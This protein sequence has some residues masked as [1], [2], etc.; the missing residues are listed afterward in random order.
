MATAMS[1]GGGQRSGMNDEMRAALVAVITS[2]GLFK[3]LDWWAQ[4][5]KERSGAKLAH[6]EQVWLRAQAM[7]DRQEKRITE[8]DARLLAQSA[9]IAELRRAL[10]QMEREREAEQEARDR[11]RQEWAASAAAFRQRIVELERAIADLQR[12]A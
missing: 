11:E 7:M 2:G 5:R 1:T 6:D 12:K 8:Q 9:E 3:A 4:R 10:A